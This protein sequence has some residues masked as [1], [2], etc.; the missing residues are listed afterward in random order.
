MF[1]E[2]SSRANHPV[3]DVSKLHIPGRAHYA[4]WIISYTLVGDAKS[5]FQR[6][7]ATLTKGRA[8]SFPQLLGLITILGACRTNEI[9][10][11]LI[12]LGKRSLPG[13]AW[14]VLQC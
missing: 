7:S 11:G 12:K 6:L 4:D 3:E 10:T 5:K 9:G 13:H 8:Y 14:H 2:L 1:G